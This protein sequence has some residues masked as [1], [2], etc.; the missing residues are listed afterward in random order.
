MT[1]APADRK[2]NSDADTQVLGHRAITLADM[3]EACRYEA[4][5]IQGTQSALMEA[6]MIVEKDPAEIRRMEVL[7]ATANFIERFAPSFFEF[8]RW[9][10]GRRYGRG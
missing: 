2:P 10:D 9:L 8:R 6:A 7:D 1:D 4:H 5:R 3:I